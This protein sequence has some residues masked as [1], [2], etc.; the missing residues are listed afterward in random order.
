MGDVSPATTPIPKFTPGAP[1]A[2]SPLAAL[3]DS[4]VAAYP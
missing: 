1:A 3:T 4:V 2:P